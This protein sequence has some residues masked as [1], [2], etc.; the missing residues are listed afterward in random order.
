MAHDSKMDDECTDLSTLVGIAEQNAIRRGDM[1]PGIGASPDTIKKNLEKYLLNPENSKSK[2]LT[3]IGLIL[4]VDVHLDK[5]TFKYGWPNDCKCKNLYEDSGIAIMS[6]WTACEG[7]V[8]DY[9]PLSKFKPKYIVDILKQVAQSE[10]LKCLEDDAKF[11]Q[12]LVDK[13]KNGV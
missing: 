1:T 6:G 11:K 10:E 4:E 13:I 8:F 5:L 7:G 12:N 9:I 3:S 2:H